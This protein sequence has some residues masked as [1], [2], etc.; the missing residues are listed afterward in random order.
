MILF[1]LSIV[2]AD[3]G[4]RM[5]YSK[6]TT[7]FACFVFFGEIKGGTEPDKVPQVLSTFLLGA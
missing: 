2:S 6:C 3:A 7:F 5:I 1:G 4:A